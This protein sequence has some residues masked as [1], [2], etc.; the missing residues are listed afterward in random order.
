M[1]SAVVTLTLSKNAVTIIGENGWR[2]FES[3]AQ[4]PDGWAGGE[5]KSLSVGSVDTLEMF[6]RQLPELAAYQPGLFL[7]HQGNLQL[8]WE[9]KSGAEVEIEFFPHKL[10]YFIESLQEEA[11]ISRERMSDLI[12]KVRSLLA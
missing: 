10:E 4:Y 11:E 12:E 7:S 2:R 3:F 5:G 1:S 8:G 6:L 9:D